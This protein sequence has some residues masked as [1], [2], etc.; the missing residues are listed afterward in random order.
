MMKM[1]IAANGTLSETDRLLSQIQQADMV[2]AAD[3]GAV[4]LHH[5]GIVPRIIVGDLDSIPENILSFLKKNRLK[6]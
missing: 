3:G 2:I 4:H 6:F 1:V 5:M